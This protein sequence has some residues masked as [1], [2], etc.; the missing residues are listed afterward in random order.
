MELIC[1]TGADCRRQNI[2]VANEVVMIIP[3][4]YSCVSVYDIVL[5][6]HNNANESEYHSI[7]SNHV[8]Y[9]LLHYTLLFPYDKHGWHWALQL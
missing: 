4:E 6:N 7:C 1:A 9:I 8:T 3:E 2:P 5:A